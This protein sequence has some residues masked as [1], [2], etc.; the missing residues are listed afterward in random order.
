[1]RHPD[2]L[3]SLEEPTHFIG[4]ARG[5]DI[6]RPVAYSLQENIPHASAHDPCLPASNRESPQSAEEK[7]RPWVLTQA[8]LS[9]CTGALRQIRG[10][11]AHS[12]IIGLLPVLALACVPPSARASDPDPSMVAIADSGRVVPA[13]H[14]MLAEGVSTTLAPA[15]VRCWQVGLLRAD[16]MQHASVSFAIAVGSGIVTER[17]GSAFTCSLT[18][19]LLKE[20]SDARHSR[21]DPIDLVADAIG[22]ALG[23][24]TAR[25]H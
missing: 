1:M 19:G 7:W 23:A 20:C 17:R 8:L 13:A 16:R 22:C 3:D 18:L 5:G 6:H 4:S 25:T 14:A 2:R 10:L 21:F 12:V 24:W 11:G 15:E 9:A